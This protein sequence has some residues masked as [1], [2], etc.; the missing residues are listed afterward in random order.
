MKQP[1]I[2]NISY[3]IIPRRVSNLA[4]LNLLLYREFKR[5]TALDCF[6]LHFCSAF[7]FLPNSACLLFFK[8]PLDIY[9]YLLLEIWGF[10]F[11][12]A[13]FQLVALSYSHDFGLETIIK[14][15][16]GVAPGVPGN[17]TMNLKT[18]DE[19]KFA[20]HETSVLC[21]DWWLQLA[22]FFGFLSFEAIKPQWRIFFRERRSITADHL[23]QE[24]KWWMLWGLELSYLV[25]Y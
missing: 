17:W 12:A 18:R 5:P 10:P 25:K 1:L 6:P 3:L 20:T 16:S 23:S 21:M 8:L 22:S 19:G 14:L 7:V 9:V 24:R 15:V 4:V 13:S 2:P 11:I